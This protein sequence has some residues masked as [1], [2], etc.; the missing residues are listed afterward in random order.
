MLFISVLLPWRPSQGRTQ[1]LWGERSQE[2]SFHRSR[3]AFQ[4]GNYWLGAEQAT[5][6][7]T[8]QSVIRWTFRPV[9]APPLESQSPLIGLQPR[10]RKSRVA[11]YFSHTNLS[12]NPNREEITIPFLQVHPAGVSRTVL[13]RR[14]TCQALASNLQARFAGMVLVSK[15]LRS[16][17]CWFPPAGASIASVIG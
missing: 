15:G 1:Y 7:C 4:A 10:A 12:L 17:A 2:L 14:H 5:F 11:D 16:L 9:I 3:L 6:C 8:A 13:D